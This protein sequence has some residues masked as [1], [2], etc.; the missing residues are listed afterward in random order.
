MLVCRLPPGTGGATNCACQHT[1][2]PTLSP[3]CIENWRN[4]FLERGLDEGLLEWYLMPFLTL[5]PCYWFY[6][7]VI[8]C[9]GLG[10]F[11]GITTILIPVPYDQQAVQHPHPAAH[12]GYGLLQ[13]N[14][15]PQPRYPRRHSNLAL[16]PQMWLQPSIRQMSPPNRMARSIRQLLMP[17]GHSPLRRACIAIPSARWATQ[18]RVTWFAAVCVSDGTT[19]N[20][21]QTGPSWRT[22][23]GGFANHVTPY[24]QPCLPSVWHWY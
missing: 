12:L 5:V 11:G 6:W 1:K 7:C 8:F 10:N 2:A 4:W 19:N 9:V 21:S 18:A 23:H 16:M 15:P 20:A 3:I 22:H 13:T 14:P 24:H 17:R